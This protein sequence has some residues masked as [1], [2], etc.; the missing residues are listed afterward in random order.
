MERGEEKKTRVM[1]KIRINDLA[2][3]LE[4]KS[5]AVLD[6]LLELGIEDKKS[7]SSAIDDELAEKIREHFRALGG[8]EV[9]HP[10]EEALPAPPPDAP[11]APAEAKKPPEERPDPAALTR[12]LAEIKE[13][14]A[15]PCTIRSRLGPCRRQSQPSLPLFPVP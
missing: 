11:L 14:R 13:K 6:Y 9:E 8:R 2:R 12:Y 4:V 10:A 3:E 15:K 7:H 1:G 5:R